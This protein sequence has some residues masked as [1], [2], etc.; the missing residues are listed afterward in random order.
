MRMIQRSP[1]GE[2]AAHRGRWRL[3]GAQAIVGLFASG[4]VALAVAEA[5]FW[6]QADL[7]EQVARVSDGELRFVSEERAAGA[8]AHRNRIRITEDS[9]ADGWVTLEQCHQDLDA[10]PAAQILFRP[11]R[12]RDL[13]VLSAEGIGQARVEGHSVQL[14]DVSPGARLCL[15]GESRALHDMGAGQYR[16]RNGPFMRR[17][18]D[19]YYP[20]RVFLDIGYPPD[21]LRLA[22][23]A[24]HSQAG[25]RVTEGRGEIGLEA[26]F[27]GRLVTCF[28]FCTADALDCTASVPPCGEEQKP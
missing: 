10:V 16:L 5:D 14:R 26:S 20:M 19:G 28:D 13:T 7:Q 15:R 18:L 4:T 22:S 9:L 17:F 1:G 11:E 27:E 23:H 12:I 8:H 6:E 2:S 21:R 25:F 24:P 3:L